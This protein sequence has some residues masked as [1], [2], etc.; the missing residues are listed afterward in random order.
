MFWFRKKKKQAI[1][2]VK[3]QKQLVDAVQN[4]EQQE[5]ARGLEAY[6]KLFTPNGEP[7][8][9]YIHEDTEILKI[10]LYKLYP[11]RIWNIKSID[12][13]L[14]IPSELLDKKELTEKYQDTLGIIIKETN[15]GS[16][17][18]KLQLKNEEYA[19]IKK[20]NTT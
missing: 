10:P 14:T 6:K 13:S 16:V 17:N 15:K 19:T 12:L 5:Q 18:I 8:Y 20:S 3:L 7:K 4:I 11:P 1:S 2:I 9:T